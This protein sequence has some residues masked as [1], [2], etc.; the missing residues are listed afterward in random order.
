MTILPQG[1]PPKDFDAGNAVAVR[2]SEK[3]SYTK[4]TPSQRAQTYLSFVQYAATTTHGALDGIYITGNVGYKKTQ[5]IPKTDV[6]ARDP[7]VGITFVKCA[8]DAC[9][10]AVPTPLSIKASEWDNN[11]FKA[12]IKTMLTSLAFD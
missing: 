1:Q 12:P 5:P 7:I 6:A 3:V 9:S 8:N 10:G 2:D 4:P 11:S